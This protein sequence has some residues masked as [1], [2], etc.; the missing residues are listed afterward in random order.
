MDALDLD[1]ILLSREFARADEARRAWE[2]ELY[3]AVTDDEGPLLAFRSL[4]SV[5]RIENLRARPDDDPLK[6]PLLRWAWF[7]TERRVNQAW[8]SRAAFHRYLE[9]H[10]L[11]APE[12]GSFTPSQIL[13]A[14]LPEDAR[15]AS[16]LEAL[17]KAFGD[18]SR[19]V[20]AHWQRRTELG[21][22]LKLSPD[23]LELPAPD[24]V[25]VARA[26]LAQSKDLFAEFRIKTLADFVRLALAR[27][28]DR[29]FPSRI[30]EATFLD[31]FR[32]GGLLRDLE[33]RLSRLPQP[34]GAASYQRA[35]V[36]FG[37]AVRVAAAPTRQP[38]VIAHDPH[39]LEAFNMGFVFGRLLGSRAFL[40]RRLG[41]TPEQALAAAR[42]SARV[43][44]LASRWFAF[45]LT[46]RPLALS[47]YDRLRR[48]FCDL[49]YDALGVELSVDLALSLPRVSPHDAQRFAGWA[50]ARER[51][52]LLEEAH[53]EDW[54]RNPRA[55]DQL[56][57]EAELSPRTELPTEELR[58]GL[59]R[60]HVEL[61]N[62]LG[63]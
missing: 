38:F 22:R 2:A 19:L 48:D 62:V 14:A 25:D 10:V 60:S 52:A 1:P 17:P 45:A 13:H 50:T 56:R 27:E 28:T 29:G 39:G 42:A 61:S 54:Y 34:L 24:V 33:P 18:H 37:H 46:L 43:E 31:W 40:T 30:N 32:E 20:G 59:T 9:K 49:A 15:R 44:L 4:L 55:I 23:A 21:R 36:Q 5:E 57:S 3:E 51:F 63:R 8:Y 12:R 16:W 41:L 35:L 7:L 53:D 26:W 6:A 47:S 58:S 11:D